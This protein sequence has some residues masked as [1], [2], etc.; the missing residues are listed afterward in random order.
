MRRQGADGWKTRRVR[1]N[2]ECITGT[3]TKDNGIND[4]VIELGVVGD[5]QYGLPTN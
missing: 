4:V 1:G 2:E 3:M 5:I